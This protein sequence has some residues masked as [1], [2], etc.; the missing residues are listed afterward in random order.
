MLKYGFILFYYAVYW[1][2]LWSHLSK[3]VFR[4]KDKFKKSIFAPTWYSLGS[5]LVAISSF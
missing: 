2:I 5:F 3:F 1:N 4:T